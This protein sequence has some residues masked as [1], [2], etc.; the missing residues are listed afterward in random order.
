MCEGCVAQTTLFGEVF[1]KIYLVRATKDGYYM[2]KGNWGLVIVNDPFFI[3]EHTPKVTKEE[4]DVTDSEEE[5]LDKVINLSDVN[6]STKSI[7]LEFYAQE[8]KSF[9][10][11]LNQKIAEFIEKIDIN[12]AQFYDTNSEK[13]ARELG[14]T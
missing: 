7:I 12:K 2:K 9:P 3:F 6:K 1:K 14:T 13:I 8:E 10:L 5:F 11:W 4:D